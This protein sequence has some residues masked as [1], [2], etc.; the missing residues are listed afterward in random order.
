MDYIYW[1]CTYVSKSLKY[2]LGT[3]EIDP[4]TN[5]NIISFFIFSGGAGKSSLSIITP[6]VPFFKLLKESTHIAKSPFFI[7][8]QVDKKPLSSLGVRLILSVSSP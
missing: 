3:L 6:I 2:C 8:Q 1:E 4:W 7:S 5:K